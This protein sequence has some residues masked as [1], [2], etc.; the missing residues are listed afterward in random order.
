MDKYC[1]FISCGN[2]KKKG[3]QFLV[4]LENLYDIVGA[5]SVKYINTTQDQNNTPLKEYGD[6]PVA[7]IFQL[8]ET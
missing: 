6:S 8:G 3:K 5:H 1:D 2:A 4:D 7:P